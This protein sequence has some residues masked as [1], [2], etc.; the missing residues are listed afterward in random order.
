MN[1]LMDSSNGNDRSK[2][3]GI[4]ADNRMMI[5]LPCLFGKFQ[6]AFVKGRRIGDN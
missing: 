2:S 1:V 3:E 6:T 5:F 4:T